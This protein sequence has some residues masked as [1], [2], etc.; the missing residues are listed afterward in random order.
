[1]I[2][3]SVFPVLIPGVVIA[4]LFS[5]TALARGRGP[6]GVWPA[7]ER[8]A[9]VTDSSL[10]GLV[11][12][13]LDTGTPVERLVMDKVRPVSVA[14]CP[15]CDFALVSG[16]EA[17]YW[18][19]HFS[20]T[21]AQLLQRKGNLDL[22]NARLEPLDI[23]TAEKKLTD[24][25]ICLVSNDGKT[26]FVAASEDHML[27]R[28]DFA[29]TPN[30]VALIKGKQGEPFGLNWDRNGDLL[31]SMHK[32][33]VWRMTAEGKVLAIYD[34]KKAGCPVGGE[35]QPNL[36]AAIDDPLNEGSLL[37]L[38]S[39]PL[40]YDAV[41]WRLSVD[42]QGRQTCTGV[43]GKIG[44]DPGWVDASGESIEF[45]RPHYFAP[46][47][48]SQPP[49]LIVTDIDNRALRLL[50]LS[51]L[52]TTS[53]MY[54]RDRVV[55]DLPQ[56]GR[57]SRSSC[58]ELNWPAA[59][60]G[61]RGRAFCVE[62]SQAGAKEVTLEQ[63]RD[64]CSAAGARLCEPAELLVAGQP[65]GRLAPGERAAEQAAWTDA[66]CA[67]CWQRNEGE[68]CAAVIEDHKTAGVHANTE[69]AQSWNSGQALVVAAT[70]TRAAATLCRPVTDQL[71]AFA[72]CCAD[73]APVVGK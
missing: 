50:D 38:A 23:R 66:A 37:I 58:T 24:G 43:A 13:D 26:A 63:A 35:K 29:S 39:N 59:A 16:G 4:L 61:P 3:L 73:A 71:T 21:V 62:P 56:Q 60:S 27:A 6:V 42:A 40:S 8:Y 14:S 54:D 34:T 25:R 20:A 55:S 17:S 57:F 68:R 51:T 48:G 65:S 30:A 47:P 31:V 45:S 52:A 15:N 28:V 64:H 69:F 36:R 11:L 49:Q 19:L 67:S 22:G 33:S 10:P 41:V 70:N 32:K 2:R 1:V 53:V 12:V 18:L 72:P 46:R 5:V 44:H 9:L 7:S